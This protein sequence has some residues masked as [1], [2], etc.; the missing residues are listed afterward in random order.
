M[1]SRE[2]AQV[3]GTA[4]KSLSLRTDL[5]IE[6]SNGAVHLSWATILFIEEPN[7]VSASCFSISNSILKCLPTFR[8]GVVREEMEEGRMM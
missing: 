6:W 1:G 5:G 3:L 8:G 4:S 2:A 7:F